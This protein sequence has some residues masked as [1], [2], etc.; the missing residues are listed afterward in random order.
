M[1]GSSLKVF[2][3]YEIIGKYMDLS[4]REFNLVFLFALLTLLF[5]F[6]P[7]LILSYLITY[8]DFINLKYDFYLI[9]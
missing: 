4:K 1:F 8:G 9:N 3:K 5:G 7:N 2:D 6:F